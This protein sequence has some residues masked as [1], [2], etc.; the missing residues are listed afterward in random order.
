MCHEPDK[1]VAEAW[2]VFHFGDRLHGGKWAL[3]RPLAILLAKIGLMPHHIGLFKLSDLEGLMTAARFWIVERE[4]MGET[5]PH[6]FIVAK[7]I[8]EGER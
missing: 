5:P 4:D 8:S 6:H 3:F 7:K 2:R 1:R